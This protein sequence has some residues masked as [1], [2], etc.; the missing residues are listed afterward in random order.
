MAVRRHPDI[1]EAGTGPQAGVMTRG[2]LDPATYYYRRLITD[3]VLAV[4]AAR[5]L[6]IVDGR[7]VVVTGRARAAGS[8]SARRRWRGT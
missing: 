5:D 2:I 8:R 1:E 7:R 6:P 3:A 4:D